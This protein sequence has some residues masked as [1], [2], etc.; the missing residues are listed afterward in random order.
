[1]PAAPARGVPHQANRQSGE[2]STDTALNLASWPPGNGM[3]WF[4]NQVGRLQYW[5]RLVWSREELAALG[6]GGVGK[7]VT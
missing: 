4:G 6:G 3:G 7:A 2:D 5:H 1:V